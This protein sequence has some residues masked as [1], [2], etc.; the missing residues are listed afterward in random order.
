MDRKEFEHCAD[1]ISF[2]FIASNKLLK[3]ISFDAKTN[4]YSI[5]LNNGRLAAF[6]GIDIKDNVNS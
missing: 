4:K 2:L 6:K 1:I 5:Y 3:T